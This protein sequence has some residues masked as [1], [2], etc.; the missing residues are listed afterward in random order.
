M[1]NLKLH[2]IIEKSESLEQISFEYVAPKVKQLKTY[3][4]VEVCFLVTFVSNAIQA[5][6]V[7]PI[8]HI[9]E[10]IDEIALLHSDNIEEFEYLKE[11]YSYQTVLL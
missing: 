6:I 4:G 7:V 3:Y 5:G 8:N 1:K 10:A 11:L 9:N 2:E